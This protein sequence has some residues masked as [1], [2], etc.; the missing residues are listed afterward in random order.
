[1]SAG[2][3][4]RGRTP[5]DT[6]RGCVI[7]F[8][9]IENNSMQNV[10]GHEKSNKLIKYN[11]PGQGVVDC[12]AGNHPVDQPLA[13]GQLHLLLL[14][15][16]HV[17]RDHHQH[18]NYQYA[19]NDIDNKNSFKEKYLHLAD[20]A[21]PAKC[22]KGFWVKSRPLAEQIRPYVQLGPSPRNKTLVLDQS[23]TLKSPSNHPPNHHHRKL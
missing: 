20:I 10:K 11:L 19:F 8:E 17:Q 4:P 23:R 5:I 15:Q 14:C 13:G 6:S 3:D 1:M 7:K 9:H 2:V 21:K 12:T 16:A 22:F 18:D